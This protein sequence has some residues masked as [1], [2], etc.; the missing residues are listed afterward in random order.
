M[1]RTRLKLAILLLVTAILSA[2]QPSQQTAW[3]TFQAFLHGLHGPIRSEAFGLLGFIN[4]QASD[5]IIE[6]TLSGNDGSDINDTSRGLDQEQCRAFEDK[7]QTAAENPA[8]RSK[9]MVLGAIGRAKNAKAAKILIGFAE[10]KISGQFVLGLVFGQLDELG[11]VAVPA[12]KQEVLSGKVA[13]ARATAAAILG[14]KYASKSSNVFLQA[15]HDKDPLVRWHA[16]MGLA[17]V[18][19]RRGMAELKQNDI[20]PLGGNRIET[21]LA[22][23]QLEDESA[24]REAEA[25]LSGTNQAAKFQAAWAI[26]RWK[27]Q[28]LETFLSH[29]AL[30]QNRNVQSV[31]AER[32]FDPN[33]PAGK[34]ALATDLESHDSV[35]QVIAARRLIGASVRNRAIA[36]LS[37]ALKSP[38]EQVRNLALETAKK[39]AELWPVLASLRFDRDPMVQTAAIEACTR[40]KIAGSYNDLSFLVRSENQDV[41]LAAA[42]GMAT[43]QPHQAETDFEQYLSS[44]KGHL[45]LYSSAMLSKLLSSSS[46]G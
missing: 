1:D 12:L 15:L 29:T 10:E 34:S 8:V 25:I 17:R 13:D 18:K 42:K 45:K 33:Q 4:N 36:V 2:A 46:A 30:A 35:L 7:L 6:K 40:L 41:S 14:R 21:L 32:Y 22:L 26:A 43:L 3:N 19:D 38:N 37:N 16:A 39:N 24:Y 44:K 9:F 27:N 23:A 5:K 28:R 31:L 11:L 20:G